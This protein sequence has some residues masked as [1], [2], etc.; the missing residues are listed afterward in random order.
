MNSLTEFFDLFDYPH[1]AKEYFLKV[2]SEL[3]TFDIA[4]ELFYSHIENYRITDNF[5]L[6]KLNTDIEELSKITKLKSR[7]LLFIAFAKMTFHMRELYKKNGYS[8][9]LWKA[10]VRDLGFKNR[11]CFEV[12]GE[13]GLFT[14]WFHLFLELKIFSLGRLQ[15]ELDRYSMTNVPMVRHGIKLIPNETNILSIHIPSDGRLSEAD[16]FDS[17][18]KAYD[19][20]K[21]YIFDKKIIFQCSSWLLYPRMLEFM[22][23]NSNLSKFINCFEIL[24]MGLDPKFSNCWRLFGRDY[25]E[26]SKALTRNTTLQKQYAKWLDNGG[27]PGYG[28]GIIVFDGKNILK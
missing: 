27:I 16:V 10:S 26:G 24:D 13:W 28:K 8:D 12:Y 14:D 9:E 2:E 25:S 18:K 11:E 3:S 19:F 4:K 15:Y 7:A 23:P 5:D 17:F 1:E 20:F 21:G 22:S 6:A